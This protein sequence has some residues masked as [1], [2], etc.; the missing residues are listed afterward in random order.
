MKYAAVFVLLLSVPA[1]AADIWSGV[2]T[3]EQAKRGEDVFLT[4]CAAACH[5]D[6]LLGNGPSP[7]LAGP[8]FMLRWEDFSMAELLEKIRT[9]M[10]KAA[11]AS[12]SAEEYLAAAIYILAENGAPAGTTK[13]SG[14]LDKIMI[15]GK[16]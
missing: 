2:F 9:T 11:P 7:G 1:Q 16:K 15:T 12:L 5:L 14:G 13:M 10:P 3:K 6:N 8:D 4:H